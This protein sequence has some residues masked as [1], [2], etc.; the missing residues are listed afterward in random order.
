MI[1]L[2]IASVILIAVCVVLAG[3][4]GS[5]PVPPSKLVGPSK[6]C[7]ENPKPVPPMQQG[8][9]SLAY[10]GA[11]AQ[12]YGKEASKLRC[13]QKWVRVVTK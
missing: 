3:C 6:R 10:S 12:Q 13:V 1:R 2:I 7:M 11:L 8:Q 9:D 5:P 4:G